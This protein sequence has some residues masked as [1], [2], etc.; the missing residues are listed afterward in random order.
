MTAIDFLPLWWANYLDRPLLQRWIA[1][2][3]ERQRDVMQS[4][5]R[6]EDTERPMQWLR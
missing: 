6:L 3:V 2:F 4:M 1:R 5:L